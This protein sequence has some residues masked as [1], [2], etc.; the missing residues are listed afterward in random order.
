MDES[1]AGMLMD[2]SFFA[3][4]RAIRSSG[5]WDGDPF[6]ELQQGVST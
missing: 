4:L 5:D 1:R 6:A 3:R 2:R